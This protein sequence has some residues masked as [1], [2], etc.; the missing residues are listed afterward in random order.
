MDQVGMEI[1]DIAQISTLN[2]QKADPKHR[3]L[4]WVLEQ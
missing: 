3:S 1:A 2:L 4:K